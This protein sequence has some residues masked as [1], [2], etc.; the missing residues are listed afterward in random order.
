MYISRLA[1]EEP[2]VL[3]QQRSRRQRPVGDLG[4]LLVVAS[5]QLRRLAQLAG[6]DLPRHDE[7]QRGPGGSFAAA[8]A[9]GEEF[10]Q[11]CG[12][13]DEGGVADEDAVEAAQ[14][15]EQGGA[16]GVEGAVEGLEEELKASKK[17]A[18]KKAAA[19]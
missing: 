15:G 13:A 17:S 9:S 19:A 18:R 6:R 1:R 12:P 14:H 16:G 8:F 2:P 11:T 5:G 7:L 10:G 3:Q 4:G